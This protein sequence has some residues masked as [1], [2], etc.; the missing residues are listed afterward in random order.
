MKMTADIK[1]NPDG[2]ITL[3]ERDLAGVLFSYRLKAADAQD[4]LVSRGITD[5]D[6]ALSNTD[7]DLP[8]LLA[9][10]KEFK[11]LQENVLEPDRNERLMVLWQRF[12]DWRECQKIAEQEFTDNEEGGTDDE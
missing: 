3:T 1:A 9:L 2:T 12:M 5:L 8:E 4:Y 6:L 7:G 11:A 10:S